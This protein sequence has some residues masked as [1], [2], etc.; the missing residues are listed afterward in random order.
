MKQSL[1]I[2]T[3]LLCTSAPFICKGQKNDL[4]LVKNILSAQ[5]TAWNEGNIDAFMKGYWHNDSLSFISK[6]G[7]TYGWDQ[8]LAHYKKSYPD[9]ATMGK[10]DFEI[11]QI[12]LL[13]PEYS[14]VLGKWHL[15]RTIG[16]AGGHFT[17]LFRK[18]NDK[19]L[20]VVDHTS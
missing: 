11:L 17:L 18:I 16:D 4:Q 1:L 8:T 15:K 13:S 19:W 7:I 3:I 12:K 5:S 20:I 9:T 6:G 10:L 2:F 14:F